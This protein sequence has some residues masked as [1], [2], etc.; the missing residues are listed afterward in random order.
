MDAECKLLGLQLP[1][2]NSVGKAGLEPA[3]VA[4]RDPKSR[5]S[6]NSDTSPQQ[7]LSSRDETG[8]II[9]CSDYSCKGRDESW[10]TIP[11]WYHSVLECDRAEFSTALNRL[12]EKLV[13][14]NEPPHDYA[15]GRVRQRSEE[16]SLPAKREGSQCFSYH[17]LFT[18][19]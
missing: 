19:G 8:Y 4:P 3:R 18:R 2:S 14:L 7:L 10:T 9:N 17:F 5:S 1:T 12:P 15:Q 13:N 6:A 11:Q 16:S